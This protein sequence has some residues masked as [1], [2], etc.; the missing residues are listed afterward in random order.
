MLVNMGCAAIAAVSHAGKIDKP[1]FSGKVASFV[2][3]TASGDIHKQLPPVTFKR[4]KARGLVAT[5]HLT[6]PLQ[7]IEGI[8]SSLTE[9]S[10][11]VLAH[12]S[13][14]TRKQVL[15]AC[16]GRSGADFTLSRVPVG[17]CDFSVKGN[18]SYD[19][20]DGDLELNHFSLAPDQRG[21]EGAKDPHYALM[22]LI[23]D[24]VARQPKLRLIASPWTAPA[25]MKDNHAFYAQGR[26]GKLLPQHYGTFGRYMA[27]Y[28]DA[29]RKEG[30]T[31][32]GLTPENEVLGN[33]G[34]WES[35]EFTP[36][37]LRDYIKLGLGPELAKTGYGDLKILAFDHNRGP[38]ALDFAR[39]I[40]SDPEASRFTW[41][42]AVHWYSNTASVRPDILDALHAIHPNKKL[43]HTEGCIETISRPEH[44]TNG[45][46]H[47]WKNDAW[48]WKED[49][50]DW[51]FYWASDK[52]KPDHP[53]YAAVH[54]YVRDMIEGFNHHF[55]G[56]IDWNLVLDKR[57]GPNHVNNFCAAPIMIDTAREEIYYTPLFYAMA[58]FSRYLKPGDRI[59][60]V[61]MA[62]P[63]L[64]PD[65]FHLT[66]A[67][68]KDGRQLTV[69]S[70]NKSHQAVTYHLQVGDKSAAIAIPANAI[71]TLRVNASSLK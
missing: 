25:W 13:E 48:W 3:S 64:G 67:V 50:T 16:F 49:A 14:S 56:W 38:E 7:A 51:G 5:I 10:A 21:F 66:A 22:P 53:K 1:R 40:F 46:F 70:L 57:G 30:V 61:D 45:V 34:Q 63:G 4:E 17:A 23:K 52:E 26:G 60:K 41:G 2:Q 27:K 39:A 19:D 58:H 44:T 33:G 43:M 28:F 62:T 15:D 69:F 37:S 8:G 32:W 24:A 59:L 71:Q 35:M 47:G 6:K 9:S 36:E 68:S 12:L 55:S 20:V 11:Y 54:R 65:D 31:F 29:Y 42:T 18:F